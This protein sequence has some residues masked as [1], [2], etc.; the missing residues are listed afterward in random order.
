MPYSSSSSSS[1]LLSVTKNTVLLSL[2][3]HDDYHECW[4]NKYRSSSLAALTPSLQP[5]NDEYENFGRIGD[6]EYVMVS[7]LWREGAWV[8]RPERPK[9]AKDEVKVP[10]GPPN[11]S[12]GPEGHRLL[13]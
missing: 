6:G 8:T 13:S 7:A 4:V 1:V 12:R 5:A 10:E 2:P 3:S 9:G 11:K